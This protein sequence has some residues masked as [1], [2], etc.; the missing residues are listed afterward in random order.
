VIELGNAQLA[1]WLKQSADTRF[2]FVYTPMCGTCRLAE[3]MLQ[4]VEAA[5]P[6]CPLARVHIMELKRDMERWRIE[7]V[8][9]LLAIRNGVVIRKL[10]AFRSV[11]Y[12]YQEILRL[13]SPSD[14]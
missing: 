10:Y 1:S 4:I 11:D 8:P 9:C 3:K 12:V 13:Q 5:L 14:G 2:V 6:D 7:S